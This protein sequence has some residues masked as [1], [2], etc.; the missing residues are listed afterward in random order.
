MKEKTYIKLMVIL[1]MVLIYHGIMLAI[2]QLRNPKA[3]QMTFW[4]H[5]SDVV[6]GRTLPQFQE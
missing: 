5:Y 6:H 2:W 3:N 4:T 1:F